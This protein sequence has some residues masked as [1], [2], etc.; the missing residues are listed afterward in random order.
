MPFIRHKQRA[1]TSLSPVPGQGRW[2]N[3]SKRG[4]LTQE[5]KDTIDRLNGLG[6]G[7]TPAEA[8]RVGVFV[9]AEVANGNWD[10]IDEY[11]CYALTDSVARLAGFKFDLGTE[12]GGALTWIVEQGFT[13]AT[14][15][16]FLSGVN[17]NALTNLA[18]NNAFAGAYL[19][20]FTPDPRYMFGTQGTGAERLRYRFPNTGPADVELNCNNITGATI[21]PAN[22]TSGSL[23]WTAREDSGNVLGGVGAVSG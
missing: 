16:G 4:T 1:I 6:N 11:Y 10:R 3:P 23:V 5:A 22:I 15:L 2:I 13:G 7:L 17:L 8:Q 9:D 21:S 20:Q 12:Q 19:T 14:A 18:Q